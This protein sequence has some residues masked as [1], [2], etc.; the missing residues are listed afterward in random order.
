MIY[1]EVT[2]FHRSVIM[3]S[4][5]SSYQPSGRIH[6]NN[7]LA[8][9]VSLRMFLGLGVLYNAGLLCI[10]L[11]WGLNLLVVFV[12]RP[13]AV[14]PLLFNNGRLSSLCT[15]PLSVVIAEFLFRLVRR[16]L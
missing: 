12:T 1:P 15:V 4:I 5:A 8:S 10:V 16:E 14:L 9:S 13:L 2:H 6:I 3:T 7:P 11:H